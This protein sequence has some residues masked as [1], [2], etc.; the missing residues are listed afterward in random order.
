MDSR[1]I[2]YRYFDG[3]ACIEVDPDQFGHVE[4]NRLA[5]IEGLRTLGYERVVLDLAG[6]RSGSLSKAA[7]SGSHGGLSG[8][9]FQDLVS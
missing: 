4:K 9:A 1:A 6:F 2:H 7:T 5:I 3:I 8:R